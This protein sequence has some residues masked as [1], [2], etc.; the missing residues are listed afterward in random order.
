MNLWAFRPPFLDGL[1]RLWAGFR[2]ASPGPEDEFALPD[3]VSRLL[4]EGLRVRVLDTD[5]EAFGLT[6]PG[7]L[8]RVRAAIA[9]RVAAGLYPPDLRVA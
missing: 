7:D 5:E 8:P 1:A 2:A 6:A 3:A 9:R 4:V